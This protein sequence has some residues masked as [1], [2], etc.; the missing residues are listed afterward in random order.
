VIHAA[1]VED[2]AHVGAG[3]QVLDKAVV[4]SHAALAPGSILTPGKVVPSGQVGPGHGCGVETW[5]GG[6]GLMGLWRQLWGGIPAKFLRELSAEEIAKIKQ[7]ALENFEVRARLSLGGPGYTL[8]SWSARLPCP[9]GGGAQGGGG[10]GLQDGGGGG[11]GL[12]G[13]ARAQQG[14]LPAPQGGPGPR[15]A[16]AGPG[17]PWA[18]LQPPAHRTTA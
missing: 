5:G 14:L 8:I 15:R 1:T 4:K 16:R 9:A 13:P 17:R 10:E 3:A 11:G 18:H 2:E 12:A 6:E 7:T